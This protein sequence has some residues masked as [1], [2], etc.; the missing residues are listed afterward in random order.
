MKTLVMYASCYGA[1]KKYAQWIAEE[2]EA[3]IMESKVV[4]ADML[5][6]YDRIIFGGGM[7]AGSINGI[8]IIKKNQALLLQKELILFSVGLLDGNKK[9]N[10]QGL[11]ESMERNVSSE[12]L[13]HAKVFHFLGGLDYA[14]LNFSHKMMMKMMRKILAKKPEEEQNESDRAIIHMKET[15]VDFASKKNIRPL[16]ALCKEV[17]DAAWN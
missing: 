9:E 4:S 2:L 10:Q 13:A 14:K 6:G 1:A 7:Y 3:D 16:I 5:K 11:A 15:P 12:I 8:E 17:Q